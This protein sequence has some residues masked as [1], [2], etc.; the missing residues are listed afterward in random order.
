MNRPYRAILFDLFGTL[1]AYGDIAAGTRVA[2]EGIHRV[3]LRLGCEVPYAEYATFWQEQFNTPLAP[4]EDVAETPFVSKLLRLFASYHLPADSEA[5]WEAAQACLAGWESEI[6]LPADT[7]PTLRSLREGY[8]L[9]L[10]SNFDHPPFARSLLERLGLTEEVDLIVIS[11]ELRIDKP[12]PRIFQ[13]AL[14]AFACAPEEAVF[15]GDSLESDIAGARA[16][17]CWPVLIDMANAHPHY[18]GARIR[19]LGELP[20]LLARS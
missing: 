11:G 8:D 6:A 13:H 9:A 16:V 12:D 20:A 14:R 1:I 3:L 15:V 19:A 7:I 4:G 10:V 2:W 5:A 18:P 17:G